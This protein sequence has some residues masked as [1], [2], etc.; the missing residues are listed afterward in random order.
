MDTGHEPRKRGTGPYQRQKGGSYYI[1][2]RWKG[3]PRIQVS[4]GTNKKRLAEAMLVTLHGLKDRRRLDILGL[5]ASGKLAIAEVHANASNLAALHERIRIA[6]SHKLSSLVDEWLN[7]LKNPG[8]ISPRTKRPYS[9]STHERYEDSWRRFLAELPNGRESTLHDLTRGFVA[10][11]RTRRIADGISHSTVNR[12]MVALESLWSW[13]EE[14]RPDVVVQRFPL[15]KSKEPAGRDRW[16]NANEIY[17]LESEVERDWWVL[18]GLLIHTGLRV[19]EA[20]ALRW[21]DIDFGRACVRVNTKYRRLKS[22]ASDRTVPMTE[23]LIGWLKAHRATVSDSFRDPV[24][25]GQLADYFAAYRR[26]KRAIR[27]MNVPSAT[28][29]D[30][31]HTYGVHAAQSGI[32]LS[33][34]QQLL[35][36][37]H[38]AM[39][40]RYSKH[41][42]NNYFVQDAAA[43]SASMRG[44]A[45]KP[46]LAVVRGN[47]AG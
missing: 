21:E 24:F 33:R 13:L 8:T 11:Y 16:L 2:V 32:P 44:G 45:D 43:I 14:R 1:D 9:E 34:I 35:G 46:R 27:A 12:D 29:H 10:D 23:E 28:I 4:T 26:F 15:G 7:W 25:T 20:Q 41:A 36:H 17:C 47:K 39:T 5:I 22:N 30:L 6:E 40:M 38:P 31:R 42:A 3:F 18:F 19:G 37:A